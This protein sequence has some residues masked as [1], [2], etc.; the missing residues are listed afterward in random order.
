M[1]KAP[2]PEN[3]G[4]SNNS[5]CAALAAPNKTNKL[6]ILTQTDT[7]VGFISQS[8]EKLAHIKKRPSAKPFI[9]I[10][11]SFANQ[12][13][14]KAV[15][16]KNKTNSGCAALAAP[17]IPTKFKNLVRRA[18]K[19]TFIVK[20]RAFRVDAGQK[21]SQILRDLK[22]HYSTSANENTKKFDR[23]FCEDKTDIIIEDKSGLHELS[24]SRL[25][26]I[27]NNKIRSLR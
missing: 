24:A 4:N 8:H 6:I 25:L 22:W 16:P 9:T 14:A 17:R 15:H 13:T 5:G 3:F 21:N 2:H 20:N 11:N 26:K 1:T 18:K 10:Y 7:T 27:N 19:T 12:G 23:N